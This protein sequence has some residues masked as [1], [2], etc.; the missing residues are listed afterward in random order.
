MLLDE[1]QKV[2]LVNNIIKKAKRLLAERGSTSTDETTGFVHL[3]CHVGPFVLVEHQRQ[4]LPGGVVRTNGLDLWK[5]IDGNARKQ[6]SV[7]YIPYE[8]K[9]FDHAGRA[10][11]IDEFLKLGDPPS[12]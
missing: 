10:T 1:E 8:L 11:W 12:V 5:I 3:D 9:Y 7:N 4:Q 6:L 2:E